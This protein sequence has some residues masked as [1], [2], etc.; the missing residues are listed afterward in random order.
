MRLYLVPPALFGTGCVLGFLGL[1]EWLLRIGVLNQFV[2]PFPSSVLLSFPRL[3][4]EEQLLHRLLL[5]G[6]EALIASLL[7]ISFAIGI[8]MF[9]HRYRI[10]RLATEPWIAAAAAAPIVLAYPLFLVIFGRSSATIIAIGFVAGLAPAL[11]KTLEG[12]QG[13]RKTLLDVGHSYNLTRSQLFWKIQFPAAIPTIFTG[14]RLGLI[15]TLINLIGVEFLINFGG[16]GQLI[17]D[18]AERYD[19]PGVFAT[20]AFVVLVS[21]FL[22]S[23]LELVERWLRPAQR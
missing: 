10:A 2:I 8:G 20:I 5:T 21:V 19:L 17:N 4:A 23:A 6:M 14:I 1:V 12:F 16:L 7:V 11:L 13:V 9:L 18:L 15:F 3:F 22:F